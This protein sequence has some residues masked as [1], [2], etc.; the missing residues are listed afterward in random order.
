M[1]YLIEKYGKELISNLIDMMIVDGTFN[2]DNMRK[3]LIKNKVIKP[4]TKHIKTYFN[5]NNKRFLAD[6]NGIC[7]NVVTDN[8]KYLIK[9]YNG[10]NQLIIGF[11]FFKNE[12]PELLK[13]LA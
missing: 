9:L 13:K 5:Y 7:R 10:R 12:I 6:E 4:T 11:S 2:E 8:G 3:L 1:D